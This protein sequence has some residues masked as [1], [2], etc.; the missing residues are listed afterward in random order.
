MPGLRRSDAGWPKVRQDF[1]RG[2]GGAIRPVVLATLFAALALPVVALSLDA[3]YDQ[4]GLGE[5]LNPAQLPPTDL[6]RWI[7]AAG[8]V[9]AAAII[10]GAIGAPIVRRHAV[11]GASFTVLTAWVVAIA[12]L[13]ILPSIAGTSSG[14]CTTASTPA[15]PRST[16]PTH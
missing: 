8:A 6:G 3:R 14:S 5:S 2:L 15:Q 4:K 11:A 16:Q 1:R 9:F 12:A 7:A 13:P 10:A